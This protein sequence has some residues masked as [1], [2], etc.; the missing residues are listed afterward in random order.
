[1]ENELYFSL[2]KWGEFGQKRF[3]G[4]LSPGEKRNI[5]IPVPAGRRWLIFKYR[6]GDMTPNVI[7]FRFNGVRNYFEENILLGSELISSSGGHPVEPKP[8]IV[9]SGAGT[10]VLENTDIVSRDY[11]IVLDFIVINKE[12]AGRIREFVLSSREKFKGDITSQAGTGGA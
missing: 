3:R 9:I 6:F 10:I 8:Y 5:N 12:I 7:N 2:S 1:M 4:T 11:E